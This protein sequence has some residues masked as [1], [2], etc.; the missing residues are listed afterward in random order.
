LA[1]GAL[2]AVYSLAVNGMFYRDGIVWQYVLKIGK[3]KNKV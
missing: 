3:I 1:G 2:A